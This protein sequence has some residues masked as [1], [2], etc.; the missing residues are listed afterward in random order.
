[1][2][3]LPSLEEMLKAG[4]H[5]GHQS[6]RRYPKMQPYIFGLRNGVHIIDLAQTQEK[7]KIAL[8]YIRDSVAAGKVL[9]ILG[10]KQQAKEMVKKY[11]ED[12]DVPYVSEGWIGGLMT[13]YGVVHK[14]IKKY[15]DLKNKRESGELKKYTKKE[16]LEFEREI[17]R[18]DKMVGGIQSLKKIPD[19]IFVIDLRHE[20]TAVREAK[21]RGVPIVALCDTN[22]N[23]EDATYPIP[24]NDDA[25]K[26]IDLMLSLVAEAVKEGRA[27]ALQVK[28]NDKRIETSVVQET[29]EE[30]EEKKIVLEKILTEDAA[31]NVS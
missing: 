5:F 3:K 30:D 1:M 19:L 4:V 16:Q 29:E 2:T 8:D 18:L 14:V 12:C 7:L 28:T 27:A 31:E 15:L 13:N 23:P 24:A 9:L 17:E 10:T 22:V 25:V 20:K 11:A 21:K 26:A 6:N